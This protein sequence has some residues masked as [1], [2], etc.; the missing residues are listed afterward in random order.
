MKLWS[1]LRLLVPLFVLGG[2]DGPLAIIPGGELSGEVAVLSASV[3]PADAGVIQLETRPGDPYS[4]NVGCVVIEN[5]IYIDPTQNRTWYQHIE[6]NPSVRLRF[7]GQEMV[8]LAVA[9]KVMDESIKAQF[10]ADRIVLRLDP[11]ARDH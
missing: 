1:V 11:R 2:C 3:I 8:Y 4:V 7:D 6:D 9:V 5:Q 10:D